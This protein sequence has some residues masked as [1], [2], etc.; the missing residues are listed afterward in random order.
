MAKKYLKTEQL[1]AC[2]GCYMSEAVKMK[3][4]WG[5]LKK[6]NWFL[7]WVFLI[8]EGLMQLEEAYRDVH[9]RFN[10]RVRKKVSF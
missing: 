4:W 5:D 1:I 10:S 3:D 9:P 2:E 7:R 6:V 8:Y